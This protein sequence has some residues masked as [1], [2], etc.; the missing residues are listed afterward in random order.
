MNPSTTILLREWKRLAKQEATTIASRE[1]AELNELL[2]QKDQIK[3][4]LK[5]Y[6]GPDGS[7][8]KPNGPVVHHDDE[9]FGRSR[10]YRVGAVGTQLIGT[11]HQSTHS[12]FHAVCGGSI[13]TSGGGG[14]I[15]VSFARFPRR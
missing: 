12:I 3:E 2:D 6:E 4:L 7:P 5:D 1:W 10:A 15:S 8:Q 11:F 9:I 13:S 14:R